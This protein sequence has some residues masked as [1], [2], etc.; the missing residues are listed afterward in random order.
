[1]E[2]VLEI[3]EIKVIPEALFIDHLDA[4]RLDSIE[5]VTI[6]K[7]AAGVEVS[8]E[9]LNTQIAAVQSTTLNPTSI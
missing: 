3:E 7:G 8:N 6:A 2:L 5:L 1:V 9:A 4:D